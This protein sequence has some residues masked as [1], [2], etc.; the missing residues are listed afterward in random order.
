[1]DGQPV[2]NLIVIYIKK[3]E[4][5]SFIGCGAFARAYL[6]LLRTPPPPLPDEMARVLPADE[7]AWRMLPADE[8]EDDVPT[9]LTPE[10]LLDVE[11]VAPVLVLL[12]G[13]VVAVRV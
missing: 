8:R 4:K 11:R 7:A 9:V 13:R 10:W 3:N 5:D 2:D 6:R 12:A 1:M